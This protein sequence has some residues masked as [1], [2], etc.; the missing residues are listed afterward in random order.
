[1]KYCVLII[2]LNVWF[3]FSLVAQNDNQPTKPCM[4]PEAKQFDF[5]L[6]E[7]D[8]TWQGPQAGIPEGQEGKAVNIIKSE[9][10]GCVI[11]ENFSFADSSFV[12]RSW[13][14]YNPGKKRWQQTWVDNNGGYLLFTGEYRDGKMI[15]Q[16]QPYDRNGKTFVS[17]MVFKNI[18]N[19]SFD[20]DWQRSND[21]GKTW[22][23]VWNIHYLRRAAE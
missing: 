23:D 15:L 22:N 9:L 14:V 7:W 2:I 8:L 12:G 1:M 19:K 5:W 18:K 3:S 16:T 6:G 4:H 13:S 10:G 17:R 11:A 20:W 21:N